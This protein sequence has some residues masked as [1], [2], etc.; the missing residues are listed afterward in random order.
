MTLSAESR[1]RFIL[2][3]LRALGQASLHDLGAATG[4]DQ[5]TIRQD[6]AFLALPRYGAQVERVPLPPPHAKF[7]P[8][9][10]WRAVRSPPTA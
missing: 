1:Q 3:A 10:L 4:V 5:T 6:L 9:V 7:A 2:S 8:R